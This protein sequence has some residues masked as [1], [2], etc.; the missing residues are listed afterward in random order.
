MCDWGGVCVCVYVFIYKLYFWIVNYLLF[1]LKRI[2][3]PLF[4]DSLYKS[5]INPYPTQAFHYGPRHMVSSHAQP[6]G[7]APSPAPMT[8]PVAENA[9]G[10]P[11]VPAPYGLISDLPLPVPT[12]DSQVHWRWNWDVIVADRHIITGYV[13]PSFFKK[14]NSPFKPFG[15]QRT[16]DASAGW[17][18][19]W[20]RDNG[21]CFRQDLMDICTRCLRSPSPFLSSQKWSKIIFTEDIL[22]N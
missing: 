2:Y 22:K 5:G 15:L 17:C 3:Y 19:I 6:T 10:P 11:R 14:M 21:V 7:P 16:M 18:W 12:G 20:M 9:Q 1:L 8:H 4:F 13:F